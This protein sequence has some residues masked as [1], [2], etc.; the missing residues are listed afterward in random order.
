MP[1]K[2]LAPKRG[3]Y[4][5]IARAQDLGRSTGR[6]PVFGWGWGMSKELQIAKRAAIR[7]ANSS[8]GAV[9]THHTQWRCMGPNGGRPLTP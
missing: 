1:T 8:I 4:T 7:M 5:C 6:S 3:W 9:D 2:A